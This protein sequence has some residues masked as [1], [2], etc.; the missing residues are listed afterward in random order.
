MPFKNDFGTRKT[1]LEEEFRQRAE[2]ATKEITE[3]NEKIDRENKQI[4][5]N[6]IKG[7][8][9]CIALSILGILVIVGMIIYFLAK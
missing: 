9:G 4:L 5:K 3:K 1:S 6:T 7:G 2:K 8:I